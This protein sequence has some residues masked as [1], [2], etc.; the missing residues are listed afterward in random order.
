MFILLYS[1]GCEALANFYLCLW[2]FVEAYL[3][4]GPSTQLHSLLL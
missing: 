2:V 4:W 1:R 3:S